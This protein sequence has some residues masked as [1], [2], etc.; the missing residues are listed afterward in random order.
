MLVNVIRINNKIHDEGG[1]RTRGNFR[2]SISGKPLITV[3]TIVLNGVSYL[4][5]T[6]QSVV[7]QDYGNIEYIIIDGGSTDGTLDII[8]RYDENIDYWISEIDRGLSDALNKGALLATGESLLYMNCGDLFY[9]STII[10]DSLSIANYP[11]NTIIYGNALAGNLVVNTDHNAILNSQ[12]LLNPICHQ[13]AI[14]PTLLQRKYLYDLRYRYSMDLD[15]WHRLILFENADFKKIDIIV[16]HYMIG[17]IT[18]KACNHEDVVYEH[19]L[20]KQSF[21]NAKGKSVGLSQL[22][23]QLIYLRIKLIIRGMV[24]E[25]GYSLIKRLFGFIA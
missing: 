25:D 24:G 9:N 14:I 23:L 10:T 18:S 6:I 17:G 21:F 4:E 7:S 8:K 5:S 22:F 15:L 13:A 20:V 16:C 19:W 11:E 1:R 2:Q 3:I 12:L